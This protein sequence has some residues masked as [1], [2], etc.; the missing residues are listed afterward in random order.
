[1]GLDYSS[2]CRGIIGDPTDTRR[3]QY[4]FEEPPITLI[5]TKSL[6]PRHIF[7]VQSLD[8]HSYGEDARNTFWESAMQK[9]YNSLL[10][11]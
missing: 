10:E 2:V 11:N 3:T 6:P 8:P 7:L 4:D 9:E 1:V 5:A